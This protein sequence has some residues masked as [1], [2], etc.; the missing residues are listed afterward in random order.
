MILIY[1]IAKKWWELSHC[2]IISI[3]M[4]TIPAIFIHTDHAS[5]MVP[6]IMRIFAITSRYS[7]HIIIACVVSIAFDQYIIPRSKMLSP[8]I[9]QILFDN[10]CHG[11]LSVNAWLSFIV[12][13]SPL[14]PTLTESNKEFMKALHF[15]TVTAYIMG[16]VI[17][18]DHFVAARSL[19]LSSATNLSAR[20]FGH[21]FLFGAFGTIVLIVLS[22]PFPFIRTYKLVYQF[23]IAFISH[24]LRDGTRRGLWLVPGYSTPPLSYGLHL[25]IMALF[26]ALISKIYASVERSKAPSTPLPSSR[27]NYSHTKNEGMSMV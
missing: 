11:C 18:A 25:A 15:T 6:P 26:P 2:A 23:S 4:M 10:I 3:D 1:W 22:Q 16:A 17:D 13:S 27:S 9:F 21:C 8:R 24:M 20:P 14:E 12:L 5:T 19:S 7:L